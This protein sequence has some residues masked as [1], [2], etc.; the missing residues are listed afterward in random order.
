M[1]VNTQNSQFKLLIVAI[2]FFFI[3]PTKTLL[4]QSSY[5]YE[6]DYA[7]GNNEY[8]EEIPENRYRRSVREEEL[9]NGKYQK[10]REGS[11]GESG[12]SVSGGG[13]NLGSL[14]KGRAKQQDVK[15]DLQEEDISKGDKNWF[16]FGT[17][18]PDNKVGQTFSDGSMNNNGSDTNNPDN[19]RDGVIDFPDPPDVP[20]ANPVLTTILFGCGL[21]LFFKLK[22]KN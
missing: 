4:A 1:F 7:M 18:N 3:V 6:D 20:I 12:Q 21:L 9:Y 13:F 14:I 10:G 5:G 15:P 2:I 8:D 17:E 11:G 19:P 22:I 16:G